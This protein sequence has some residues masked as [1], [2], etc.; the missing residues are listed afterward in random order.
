MT[1]ESATIVRP[2]RSRTLM[3]SPFLS[4]AA[5]QTSAA[6][7]SSGRAFLLGVGAAG[8]CRGSEGLRGD[9]EAALAKVGD[10][11]YDRRA[12]GGVEIAESERGKGCAIG[13]LATGLEPVGEVDDL[14]QR[15][16]DRIG[17]RV[18]ANRGEYLGIADPEALARK[19]RAE[20]RVQHEGV[21]A[22]ERV[23]REPALGALAQ[24]PVGG[25]EPGQ[26]V[27]H[28]RDPRT[29]R[30]D[31]VRAPEPRGHAGDAHHARIAMPLV[32]RGAHRACGA[33]ESHPRA[34]NRRA[35]RVQWRTSR[36]TLAPIGRPPSFAGAYAS[37]AMRTMSWS[38]NALSSLAMT[39]ATLRTTPPRSRS[40][41]TTVARAPVPSATSVCLSTG[42]VNGKRICVGVG[43][44]R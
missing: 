25:I 5:S 14:V 20:P 11:R 21:R 41:R 35:L 7:S 37:C 8:R 43:S 9:G 30:V 38:S 12:H 3:S 15:A 6:R 18:F 28:R 39:T 10:R 31:A 19:L 32:E 2:V 26:I 23:D 4:S 22:L 17:Q 34:Q 36:Q 13:E 42:A 44:V 40:S 24:K 33:H 27:Q 29:P 1:N 16:H